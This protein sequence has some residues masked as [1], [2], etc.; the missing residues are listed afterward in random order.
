MVFVNKSLCG[1]GIYIELDVYRDKSIEFN[2]VYG[3]CR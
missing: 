3:M 1:L 2:Y